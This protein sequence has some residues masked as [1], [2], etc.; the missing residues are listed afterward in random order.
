MFSKLH[1][2]AE[3][4]V[5]IL[6]IDNRQYGHNADLH[7]DFIKFLNDKK[8]DVIIPYGN[9][10]KTRF[11]NAISVDFRNVKSQLD[12][13]V[14]RYKPQLILTYNCNGS[15]YEV[16][17]DNVALYRWVS[18]SLSKV[19]I[20]KFHITTDYCRP[21]F[22]QDQAD[23]F[24][25]VGYSAAIFRH[26]ES[27]KYPLGIPK[28]WLPF[29]INKGLYERNICKDIHKKHKMVGFIGAAHNTGSIYADRIAAID[30]LL[31]RGLL[32]T[33][34]VLNKDTFSRE[35]LLGK[36][37]IR[38]ITNNMFGLTC[39]GT[40]RYFTA[41]YLQIPAAYSMLIC[42]DTNGLELL[43][44]D[45]Y[46][47]YDRSNLDKLYKDITYH[48]KSP[49][50]TRDKVDFLHKYVIENHNHHKRALDL[51]AIFKEYI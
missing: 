12:F 1:G 14:K 30:F 13:I 10:L 48:I 31:E 4:F 20:P 29:S 16:G 28:F 38:F 49:K 25:Y 50:T 17:R 33:T 40:C 18:D 44:K 36:D 2:E 5:R 11:S 8:Y 42:S 9:H 32:K 35:I 23:W 45:A 6:Y 51:R 19:G 47:L 24:D 39:G 43:P 37:Y 41:K 3:V 26:K 7:I 27:L 34:K 46:I 21:G 22:R 15:S